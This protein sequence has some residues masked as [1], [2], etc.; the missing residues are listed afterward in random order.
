MTLARLCSHTSKRPARIHKTL[1]I[2]FK[3]DDVVDAIAVINQN[4]VSADEN[5]TVA[6]GRRR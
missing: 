5:V 1:E 2:K 3:V 6:A 4:R